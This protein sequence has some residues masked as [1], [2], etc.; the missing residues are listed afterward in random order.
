MEPTQQYPGGTFA[1]GLPD[2][3]AMMA[4]T[5]QATHPGAGGVCKTLLYGTWSAA[6][7]P[8]RIPQGAAQETER[9]RHHRRAIRVSTYGADPRP[10]KRNAT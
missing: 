5:N 8:T 4:P 2:T 10:R 1:S 3:D 7:A 9:D 6:T